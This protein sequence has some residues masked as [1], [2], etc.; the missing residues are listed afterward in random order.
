MLWDYK[1]C[2][3][4]ALVVILLISF[5]DVTA[6]AM[7][8]DS[9]PL[10]TVINSSSDPGNPT[11]YTMLEPGSSSTDG[12]WIILTGGNPVRIP[13]LSVHYTGTDIIN[14]S[15]G[16]ALSDWPIF[17]T[18]GVGSNYQVSISPHDLT[19]PFDT[20]PVYSESDGHNDVGATFYG[21]MDYKDKSL[22]VKLLDLT[23]VS[24]KID[25]TD[26]T[27]I[28]NSMKLLTLSDIKNSEIDSVPLPTD[29]RGD[30]QSI[31]SHFSE[32]NDMQ[33]G[34]YALVVMDN[35]N[36]NIPCIVAEAPIIVTKNTMDVSMLDTAPKPGDWITFIENQQGAPDGTY[37]YVVAM[38]PEADYTADIQVTSSDG[39]L[40]G[41]S[42]TFHGLS[43]D[44]TFNVV[45]DGTEEGTTIN[46]NGLARHETLTKDK[47]QDTNY[48]QQLAKDELS[49][50]N[51][52]F[53]IKTTTDTTGVNIEVPTMDTMPVGNYILLS[54]AVDRDTGKIAAINQTTMNL[55]AT[56]TYHLMK[57]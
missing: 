47:L 14:G 23:S 31:E 54:M 53:G 10:V 46:F 57:D 5:I 4:A 13:A 39:S 50:S 8:S 3:K 34:Y 6:M 9:T 17:S 11:G 49:K 29:G 20:Y 7:P 51:I 56:C 2:F 37:T 43:L 45:S 35:S 38:V 21:S 27:S 24:D 30:I 28:E 16:T 25:F 22:T 40:S 52:A 55:G 15:P 26:I 12:N 36:P 33:Q 18:F 44:E 32:L 48:M 42:M 1:A 19:V 41:T